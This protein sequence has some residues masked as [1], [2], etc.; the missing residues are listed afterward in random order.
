MPPLILGTG[1][2]IA[3]ALLAGAL[4]RRLLRWL[5]LEGADLA[6]RSTLQIGLGLGVLQFLP[7]AL[8]ALGIGHPAVFRGAI[9]ALAALLLPDMRAVLRESGQYV[10]SLR[11]PRGWQL[12]LIAGLAMLLA[13]LYVRALAPPSYG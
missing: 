5:R 4:G 12:L 6:E 8:F 13:S 7:F 1:E 11:A 10:K 2:I 9:A 3:L